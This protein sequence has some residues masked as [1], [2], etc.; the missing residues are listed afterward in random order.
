M[1]VQRS[2]DL[3]RSPSY[4]DKLGLTRENQTYRHS[5]FHGP[6]N[7]CICRN[8]LTNLRHN[9]FI[10]VI[11]ESTT[12]LVIVHVRLTENHNISLKP[13]FFVRTLTREGIGNVIVIITGA[14][15]LKETVRTSSLI[16]VNKPRARVDYR[17]RVVLFS[18][19]IIRK[20]P[21]GE[22]RIKWTQFPIR[23]SK[24]WGYHRY[25]H[26]PNRKGADQAPFPLSP[27]PGNFIRVDQFEFS[28]TA[29]P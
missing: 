29:F 21:K 28:V 8:L 23:R 16:T 17:E 1:T 27:L 5:V 13:I 9:V 12:Q 24:F 3:L 25:Y 6:E 26:R 14:K 22:N 19:H 2:R 10:V 4:S 18:P 15:V 11:A 20:N 7:T